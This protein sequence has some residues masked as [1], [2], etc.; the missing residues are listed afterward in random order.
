MKAWLRKIWRKFVG[1]EVGHTSER[2]ESALLGNR[3]I[4]EDADDETVNLRREVLRSWGYSESEIALREEM[5]KNPLSPEEEQEVIKL[6][7]YLSSGEKE[8]SF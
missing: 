5:D 6:R 1:L 3:S 4:L 8:V 7:G 2:S